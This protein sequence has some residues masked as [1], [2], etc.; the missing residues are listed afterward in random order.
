MGKRVVSYLRCSTQDQADFGV[1]LENQSARIKAYCEYRG[2]DLVEEIRDSGISGGKNKSRGGFM[3][4]LDRAEHNGFD[5][6]VLYSLERISRDMLTLLALERLFHE[7]GIEV[8]T[9]DDGGLD[10]STPDKWLAF[11]MK[12]VL[13]EHERRQV[14]YRTRRALEH[15]KANGKVSGRVPY[16]FLR[17]GDNLVP[18]DAEQSVIQRINQSYANGSRLK[19]IVDDLNSTGYTTRTGQPWKPHQ[20]SRLIEDY[21]GSFKKSKTATGEAIKAFILTIA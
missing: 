3:E 12:C 14:A 21:V 2:Y 1:S 4:L 15:K 6:V 16:G 20:V 13:S 18:V 19:D 9:I 7:Y 5:C 11:A 17:E 8:E 10:T